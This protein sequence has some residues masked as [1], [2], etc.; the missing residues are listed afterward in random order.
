MLTLA[1]QYMVKNAALIVSA[2]ARWDEFDN[3]GTEDQLTKQLANKL[4]FAYY[5]QKD[6]G[7]KLPPGR[8]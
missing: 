2:T 3:D 6:T 5:E 7:T 8:A 4:E 1:D